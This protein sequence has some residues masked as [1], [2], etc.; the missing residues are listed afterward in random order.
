VHHRYLSKV[1][2]KL[3]RQLQHTP[4]KHQQLTAQ[5]GTQHMV[6]SLTLSIAASTSGGCLYTIGLPPTSAKMV[7]F[8]AAA[9]ISVISCCHLCHF[10]LSF[11]SVE[12]ALLPQCTQL[13][14]A[15]CPTHP[16]NSRLTAKNS[17]AQ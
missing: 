11:P 13:P 4:S 8:M 9:V 6:A 12:T 17:K 5:H 1:S 2:K 3:T 16:Q 14:P 10:L 15:I 7:S